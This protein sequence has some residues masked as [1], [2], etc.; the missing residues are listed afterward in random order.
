MY[1]LF[2]VST[3]GLSWGEVSDPLILNAVT[4]VFVSSTE[5]YASKD[6]DS[7]LNGQLLRKE[8][9]V[10]QIFSLYQEMVGDRSGEGEVSKSVFMK[11][12]HDPRMISFASSLEID[13]TDFEQF[14]DVLSSKGEHGIDLDT[15]VDGCIRLRG[16]AK[17]MDVYDLLIHQQSLAKE[18]E[19]IRSLLEKLTP[20][21]QF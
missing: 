18:V 5:E 1:T 19:F 16:A 2:K 21:A 13:N 20:R 6:S 12:I 8:Q 9:Y 17:S 7:M 10:K 14:L 4:A 3:G 11:Y 15:F